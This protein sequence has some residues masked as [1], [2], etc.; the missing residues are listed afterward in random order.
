MDFHRTSLNY[1]VPFQ[2][3]KGTGAMKQKLSFANRIWIGFTL[4]SMFFGVGSL[5]FIPYL[6]FCAGEHLGRGIAGFWAGGVLL[7]LLGMGA[8][9]AAG[10]PDKMVSRIHPRCSLVFSLLIYLCLGPLLALP[11][12]ARISCQLGLV[13]LLE[14]I[15]GKNLSPL[16]LPAF[17]A[18]A[19]LLSL[20]PA[21]L[22]DRL[23]KVTTPCLFFLL[24]LIFIGCVCWPM[25]QW[26][27]PLPSFA[28][29]PALEG[30]LEGYQLMGPMTALAFCMILTLNI[31]EKGITSSRF[32]L[33]ESIVICVAAGLLLTL[34]YSIL[35]YIGSLAGTGLPGAKSGPEILSWAADE[36][37]NKNGTRILAVIFFISCLNG[38]ACF[39]CC[40]S[41]Y[42]FR[43]FPRLPYPVWAAAISGIGFGTAAANPEQLWSFILPVLQSIYPTVI[44]LIFLSFI[45]PWIQ[46]LPLVYPFCTV[47]T[48]L[49]G[50]AENLEKIPG[51]KIHSFSLLKL[52]PGYIPGFGWVLPAAAGALGGAVCSF[53][54]SAA[55][56][57]QHEGT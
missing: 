25:G 38:S 42:L 50:F 12:T 39:I 14:E 19:Y 9:V 36:L 40:C 22:S 6:G 30:F 16:C 21:K 7:P 55:R 34:V 44:V 8:A 56:K 48:L 10:G 52:L 57:K 4:F 2:M 15:S 23:G 5:Q 46:R 31:R 32:I 20:H 1:T 18:A 41:E 43:H 13:P 17:F 26:G 47:M 11:E 33:K 24:A 45:H 53:F 27:T 37:Y 3:E 51:C 35:A 49:A 29:T 54:L 28:K